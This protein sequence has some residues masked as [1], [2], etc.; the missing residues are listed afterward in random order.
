MPNHDKSQLQELLSNLVDE[1][2]GEQELEE[3]QALL[4]DDPDAQQFYIRYTMLH[5]WLSWDYVEQSLAESRLLSLHNQEDDDESPK[6]PILGFLGDV[7]NFFNHYSPL[8]FILLFVILGTT[9]LTTSYWLSNLQSGKVSVESDFVAQIT[10]TSKVCQWSTAIA[11]PTGAMQLRLG[12]KLRLEKG[13]A[14]VTY[15]NRAVVILEGPASFTVD[16]PKSGYLSR[17]K[18]TARADTEQSRQFTIGTPFARFVDLGTEFGV[19]VD[20][21]GRAAVAVFE[22]KVNAEAKLADGRWTTPISLQEGEAV[23]CERTKFIHQVALRSD[24]PTLRLPPSPPSLSFQRWL[25]ASRELQSRQDLVAYY[26]FQPD[27]SNPKVL[28]NR[29]PTGAAFNGELLNSTWVD[30]RF[31]GKSALEFMAGDSGVRV[32]IPGEYRQ[33]TLIAWVSSNKLA[34]DYNGILM[35]DDWLRSK[36]L[37]W[38]ILDG[39]Q[40]DLIVF[41]QIVHREPTKSI[42]ADSLN[43]WCMITGVIDT[44][45]NKIFLYLNG[46]YLDTFEPEF[47][48]AIQIG[49]ATIGGWNNQGKGDSNLNRTHN[50]SGRMDELM[51]FQKALTADEIKQIYEAGKP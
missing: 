24:Y 9:L 6:S 20:A 28:L 43:R 21:Q 45:T 22:G 49:S 4:R 16:S 2:L 44:A 5:S 37:H 1:K 46:E 50:L 13:I 7:A 8:S 47:I 3:L 39:G 36:E 42:P 51:I 35:S 10:A 41:G 33:M 11:P 17:G 25:D 34:N 48:P 18:L 26:D 23:V 32:N 29:A 19:M 40:V 31:P 15:S 27:T 30:G 12:Q 38:V 14:Q